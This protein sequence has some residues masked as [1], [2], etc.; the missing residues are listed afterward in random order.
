ML[1]YYIHQIGDLRNKKTYERLLSV[2]KSKMIF[3]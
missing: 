2:L 1:E 3:H